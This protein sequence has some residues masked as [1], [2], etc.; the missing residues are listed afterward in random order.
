MCQRRD[1][2]NQYNFS[3]RDFVEYYIIPFTIGL[4]VSFS[5]LVNQEKPKFVG[6]MV[7]HAWDEPVPEFSDAVLDSDEVGPFW[8][9][10]LSIHQNNNEK[11]G[12]TIGQQLSPNPDTGPFCVVLRAVDK[13]IAVVTFGC[14][15]YTRLWCVYELYT[16]RKL[17]VEIELCSFSGLDNFGDMTENV[18]IANITTK[19]DSNL[20]RCGNPKSEQNADERGIRDAINK[21]DGRFHGVNQAVEYIRLQYLVTYPREEIEYCK[22]RGHNQLKE[23]IE[24]VLPRLSD[25]ELMI[26][27]DTYLQRQLVLN[28]G[29]QKVRE[30]RFRNDWDQRDHHYYIAKKS[31]CVT[32]DKIDLFHGWLKF[33]EESID[34]GGA[35]YFDA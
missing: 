2:N 8:I 35:K 15:I 30:Q 33:L 24:H 12:V 20:A 17:G 19:V 3:L 29:Y 7:S 23:A 22:T 11:I 16:A 6:T 5:L 25:N 27:F 13:M 14:D 4:G 28:P 18:C 9:C 1:G 26:D 32:T 34:T 31:F 21:S 10:A